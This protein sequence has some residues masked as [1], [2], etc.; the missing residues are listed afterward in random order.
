MKMLDFNAIQRPTWPIKLKDE[1]QT[2]VNLSLPS[3]GL[4]ERLIAATPTLQEAAKTKDGRTI[5]AIYDL[6]AEVMSCNEDGF[7]FTGDELLKRYRLTLLDLFTFWAGY[8]DFVKEI[9]NA[10]N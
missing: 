6:L 9:Q 4:L 10:K 2:V 8:L 3:T 5:N 7:T 1:A